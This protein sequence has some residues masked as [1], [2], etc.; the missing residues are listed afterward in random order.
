[1]TTIVLFTKNLLYAGG[2]LMVM[3]NLPIII[4]MQA[5]V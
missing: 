2:I 4:V 5:E 1:M 3:V